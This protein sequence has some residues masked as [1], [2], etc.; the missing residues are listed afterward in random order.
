MSQTR[1]HGEQINTGVRSI[2]G[3]TGTL[4]WAD[5]GGLIMIEAAGICNVTIPSHATLPLRIGAQVIVVLIS[6]TCNLVTAGSVSASSVSGLAMD[7]PGQFAFLTK[8]ADNEW[9]VKVAGNGLGTNP[10]APPGETGDYYDDVI[11]DG[12][13]LY[14]QFD[15]PTG[16]VAFDSSGNGYDGV[17]E[18]TYTLSQAPIVDGGTATVLLDGGRVELSSY[19]LPAG[20]WSVEQWINFAALPDGA[21]LW[22]TGPLNGNADDADL[23]ML[24]FGDGDIVNTLPDG[25]NVP[26][27]GADA[28]SNEW[29]MAPGDSAVSTGTDYYF[30]STY[31]AADKVLS[32]WQDKVLQSTEFVEFALRR[33]RL[34]IGR[35]PDANGNNNEINGRPDEFAVI[36]SLLSAQSITD[37]YDIGVG[38]GVQAPLPTPPAPSAFENIINSK[39]PLLHYPTNEEVLRATYDTSGNHNT[40]WYR[41]GVT[42]EQSALVDGGRQMALFDGTDGHIYCPV[43]PIPTSGADWAIEIYFRLA[44]A[45]NGEGLVS[46]RTDAVDI[47]GGNFDPRFLMF[48]FCN[49]SPFSPGGN[50]LMLAARYNG[51]TASVIA[52]GATLVDTDYHAIA[53]YRDS[54]RQFDLYVNNAQVATKT[55]PN[56]IILPGSSGVNKG[57]Y[58]GRRHD[59]YGT[60]TFAHGRIHTAIHSQFMTASDVTDHYNA[61]TGA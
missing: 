25:G 40:G 11:A 9:L 43:Q 28:S 36:P 57:V 1:I 45:P 53:T 13:D 55:N 19:E 33:D 18:G 2:F 44:T 52:P 21:A 58:V 54:D 14:L 56:Q 61:A 41:G 15:A 51:T 47:G 27:L 20:D 7:I 4:T 26:F 48:G 23:V 16:S 50:Q 35:R 31:N 46:F 38:D 24:G 5:D 32:L 59:S 17:Y 6:G 60:R 10:A 22:H 29:R 30:V 39:S 3:S 37:R 42:L 34:T 12:P 8:M 49:G